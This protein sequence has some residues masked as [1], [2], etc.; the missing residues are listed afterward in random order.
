MAAETATRA[1][2]DFT[3]L[4]AL[5]A[6]TVVPTVPAMMVLR[7]TRADQEPAFAM[8]DGSAS[9]QETAMPAPADTMAHLAHHAQTVARGL[10]MMALLGIWEEAGN[11]P[12]MRAGLA[13][14]ATAM[15]VMRA[16]L[17]LIVFFAPTAA[18]TEPAMMA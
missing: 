4:H 16:T 6:R 12:V 10:A 14:L 8:P 7:E 17:D 18:F 13:P 11:A 2:A 15:P 1:T 5:L 9:T 3:A